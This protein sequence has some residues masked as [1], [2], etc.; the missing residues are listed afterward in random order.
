VVLHEGCHHWHFA[1]SANA[2]GNT[3]ACPL[4]VV[5]DPTRLQY[6]GIR[7]VNLWGRPWRN[8]KRTSFGAQIGSPAKA[9]GRERKSLSLASVIINSRKNLQNYP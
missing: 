2:E 4:Q 6:L 5:L 8:R 9:E 1:F 3:I 7:G